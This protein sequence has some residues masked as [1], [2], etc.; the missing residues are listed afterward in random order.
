MSG[1]GI[2]FRFPVESLLEGQPEGV[3]RAHRITTNNIVALSQQIASLQSQITVLKTPSAAAST[4]TELIASGVTSFNSKTGAVTYFPDLATVNDQS[5]MTGYTTQTGDNGALILLDSIYPIGVTLN[6]A[7]GAPW[8]TVIDNLGGGTATLTPSQGL[9]NGGAS[10]DVLGA[11][12]ALVWFDGTNFWAALMPTPVSTT[13]VDDETVAGS[14]T[15]WSLSHIPV[16]GCVPILMVELAGF[17]LIG[18]L[19]DSPAAYGYTISG[20]DIT[21]VSSYS[22]GALHA[23]YRS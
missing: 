1:Q 3:V 15:A 5:G 4:V 7:L 17:G 13:F 21:T 12:F 14:A 9:I 11:N 8:W 20:V 18:L 6:F 19:R 22:A 16:A 23:W 10:L 2:N